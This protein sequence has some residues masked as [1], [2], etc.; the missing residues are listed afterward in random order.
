MNKTLIIVLLLSFYGIASAGEF[1]SMEEALEGLKNNSSAYDAAQ[2]LALN[3]AD[4]AFPILTTIFKNQREGWFYAA[5]SLKMMK[6]E[7]AVDFFIELLRDNFYNKDEMGQRIVYGY[8]SKYGCT[9]LAN[10]L[11]EISA[12]ILGELKNKKAVSVLRE[13]ISQDS[14]VSNAYLALY[15][16]DEIS[17]DQFI[18]AAKKETRSL[19]DKIARIGNENIH[20]NTGFA[21][22][23]FDKI[24]K[25]LPPDNYA[26]A[27]AHYSK[28][29]C[30]TLLEQ[31]DKALDECDRV[32]K[33]TQYKNLTDQIPG[34]KEEIRRAMK[35]SNEKQ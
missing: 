1:K 34:E 15:R 23:V 10:R 31:Y 28:I 30:Y 21:I 11:G 6:S 3:K 16:M 32:A 9:V 18:E 35:A 2:Y 20:G 24:I 14:L 27:C 25:E 19:P 22:E 4:E 17:L 26:V 29:Q 7:K 8:G 33:Y 13:A 5:T 12:D